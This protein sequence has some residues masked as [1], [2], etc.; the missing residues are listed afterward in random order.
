MSMLR[1]VLTDDKL[2]I[3]VSRLEESIRATRNSTMGFIEP[4]SGTL[5]KAGN[6]RSHIIFGRRGTGKSSLLNKVSD[7]LSLERIPNAYI[8]LE[9]YKGHSYPDVLI[10]ILVD[11]FN[12]FKLWLETVGLNPT[13]KSTWWKKFFGKQPTKPPLNRRSVLSL[14][15]DTSNCI[16]A[17]SSQLYLPDNIPTKSTSTESVSSK[18]SAN[19]GGGVTSEGLSIEAKL[20][21]NY[22]ASLVS[23]NERTYGHKKIE[24]LT[25]HIPLYQSLFS[26]M[27]QLSGG[28]AFLLLDDLY[29]IRKEEQYLV[30]D[31][32]HRVSKQNGLVLK[33]GTIRHRSEWYHHGNPSLGLKLGDDVDEINLDLSLEKFDTAKNFLKSILDQV[34]VMVVGETVDG[35]VTNG[36]IERL[37]LASGGV[38]RDFLGIFIKAIEIRR[39][40][41]GISEEFRINVEDVN[42]ASGDY[43]VNK[44][45]ELKI[46]TFEDRAFLEGLFTR[47]CEFCIDKNKSNIFLLPK[48]SLS[49]DSKMIQELVDLRLIHFVDSRV[50]LRKHPGKL[51]EAYMLDISQYSGSRKRRG[52]RMIEFWKGGGSDAVRKEKLLFSKV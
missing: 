26:K 5:S 41:I 38:A 48:D 20:G 6:R 27:R 39:N 4:A 16:K 32:L 15:S 18:N 37:V 8:D 9:T 10:S 11:I 45:E 3:L 46:D 19:I 44:R 43:D 21:E 50:T 24:F 40:K 2:D 47:I 36:C 35:M 42:E 14:I 1:R 52:F 22:E 29:H 30:L 49:S 31:F 34:I 28:D 12:E 25:Q 51:F 13:N 33:V 23:T 7:Q 17:L